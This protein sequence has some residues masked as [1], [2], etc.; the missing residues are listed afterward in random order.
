MAWTQPAWLA[1]RSPTAPG[2]TDTVAPDCRRAFDSPASVEAALTNRRTSV[3]SSSSNAAALSVFTS[4]ASS[5]F[6]ASPSWLVADSS[7][8]SGVLPNLQGDE[9]PRRCLLDP[10]VLL[11]PYLVQ[12]ASPVPGLRQRARLLTHIPCRHRNLHGVLNGRHGS[13]HGLMPHHPR[14]CYAPLRFDWRGSD[15]RQHQRER[16]CTNPGVAGSPRFARGVRRLG[17]A[18]T[19]WGTSRRTERCADRSLHRRASSS[20]AAL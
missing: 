16:R 7:A 6:S 15:R 19:V 18:R 5:S 8:R 9:R 4:S 17:A 10:L 12:G 3:A 20:V 13:S 2:R 14:R 11:I 1:T